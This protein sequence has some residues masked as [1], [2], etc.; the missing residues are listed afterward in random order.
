MTIR[1]PVRWS[2]NYTPGVPDTLQFFTIAEEEW[3]H[4][5]NAPD[6]WDS[7]LEWCWLNCAWGKWE[8]V[9]VVEL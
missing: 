8:D 7:R 3:A 2:R 4:D 1:V 6:G 5:E 9:P